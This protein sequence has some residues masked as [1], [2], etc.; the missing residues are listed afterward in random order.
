ME[1]RAVPPPKAK[2]RTSNRPHA[3]PEV[4]ASPTLARARPPPPNTMAPIPRRNSPVNSEG[5]PR[6]PRPAAPSKSRDASLSPTATRPPPPG[7]RSPSPR[8]NS[9]AI[10]PRV[11]PTATNITN[12]THIPAPKPALPNKPA[13]LSKPAARRRDTIDTSRKPKPVARPRSR[14]SPSSS[15]K[16]QHPSGPRVAPTKPRPPAPNRKSATPP[17][18]NSPNDRPTRDSGVSNSRASTASDGTRAESESPLPAV[19]ASSGF[20]RQRSIR[21]PASDTATGRPIVSNTKPKPKPKRPLP[22]ASKPRK[23]SETSF[24]TEL[25]QRLNSEASV[26]ASLSEPSNDNTAAGGKSFFDGLLQADSS[27]PSSRLSTARPSRGSTASLDLKAIDP[28]VTTEYIARKM[29]AELPCKDYRHRLTKHK[30]CFRSRDAIDWLLQQN[31][32][33]DETNACRLCSAMMG[34]GMLVHVVDKTRSFEKG[35]T[36]SAV[37]PF[38]RWMDEMYWSREGPQL[39]FDDDCAEDE[40]EDVDLSISTSTNSSS[41][42]MRKL[43][44]NPHPPTLAEIATA[45]NKSKEQA[46]G[47]SADTN[48]EDDVYLEPVTMASSKPEPRSKPPPPKPVV[49]APKPRVKPKPA[50]SARPAPALSVSPEDYDMCDVHPVDEYIAVGPEPEVQPAGLNVVPADD[51]DGEPEYD[52]IYFDMAKLMPHARV[53]AMTPGRLSTHSQDY[54]DWSDTIDDDDD[55]DDLLS[56]KPISKPDSSQAKAIPAQ[57]VPDLELPGPAS[58]AHALSSATKTRVRIQS[59]TRRLPSRRGRSGGSR[60]KTSAS[61]APASKAASTTSSPAKATATAK[62]LDNDDQGFGFGEAEPAQPAQPTVEP[63]PVK[64]ENKASVKESSKPKPAPVDDLFGDDDDDIFASK[65]ASKSSK[66]KKS[67]SSK[68]S[69]PKPKAVVDDLFDDEPATKPAAE[70][71]AET[72]AVDDIF[73]EDEGPVVPASSTKPKKIKKKKKKS[74]TPLTKADLDDLFG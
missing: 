13:A 59:G 24:Q 55:D 66:P 11:R 6:P 57:A 19:P 46:L 64:A 43:P 41:T 27:E 51:D 53:E 14:T 73:G 56:T 52:E 50:P 2:P 18:G 71:A 37:P 74:T 70:T 61:K 35:S 49:A 40:Q 9:P 28:Y 45:R 30:N 58:T 72:A 17:L 29:K 20:E 63:E 62:N 68:K 47:S 7:S 31:V 8:T 1:G 60:A 44:F 22:P 25:A 12:P 34:Y 54:S 23:K 65:P 26:A 32:A 39:L 48:V 3:H 33:R 21:R 5:K 10:N 36:I 69:K 4:S 16:H 38:Y 67:R 42:P 15:L